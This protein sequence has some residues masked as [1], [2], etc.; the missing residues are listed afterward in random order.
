MILIRAPLRVSFGGGGT[1]LP[2]YYE[3]HEGFVI[4]AA[5]TRYSY[6]QIEE[7]PDGSGSVTSADYDQRF[8]WRPGRPPAARPPLALPKAALREFAECGALSR[9]VALSLASDVPPGSGLGSSSA[10][11]VAIL[12]ALSTAYDAPLSGD[13]LASRACA[14]EIERLGMPIGKQDQ[15]ASAYGG[16]NTIAFTREG[17]SVTPLNITEAARE[18]LSKRL[19]LFWTGCSRDSTNILRAQRNDTQTRADIVAL[20]HRIK[21]LAFAMRDTLEAGEVNDFGRLLDE[22]WQTKR[23]LSNAIS[24]SA[25]DEWYAVAKRAGALGGKITGAGG[26]GFLLVF[27]PPDR[28]RAVREALTQCGLTETPFSFDMR[29][30]TRLAQ[31]PRQWSQRFARIARQHTD[32]LPASIQWSA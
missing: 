22:A 19:Q 24:S 1:D 30:V 7:T 10:M 2:A 20:L 26:G 28:R 4:S 17:V 16:L 29:G 5:I 12:Q 15:Y 9:G 8:N 25:I 32:A 14:L 31:T 6:A 3:R 13:A 11:A 27:T 21:A 23:R 18:A